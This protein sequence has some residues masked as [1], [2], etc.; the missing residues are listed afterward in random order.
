MDMELAEFDF[1]K[2]NK[3]VQ[4]LQLELNETVHALHNLHEPHK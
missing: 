4:I 3:T 1:L 2:T